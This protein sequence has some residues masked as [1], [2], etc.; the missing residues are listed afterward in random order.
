MTGRPMSSTATCGAKSAQSLQRRERVV[1]HTH[2]MAAI[3]EHAR[4]SRRRRRRCRRRA[5]RAARRGRRPRPVDG[6]AASAS[7]ARF[8]QRQAHD[9][10]A[11]LARHRHCARATL[12]PCSS[13]RLLT[14][15]RPRPETALRRGRSCADPGRNSSK[16]RG[17]MLR[18]DA[19]RRCRVRAMT[20]AWRRRAVRSAR[21]RRRGAC[22]APRWSAGWPPPGPAGSG[23]RASAAPGLQAASAAGGRAARAARWPSRRALA[24]TV[25][26]L[27]GLAAQLDLA[28]CDARH[29]QQVV[30][31]PHQVVDL[32]LDDLL[33]A[34]R[35]V[36]SPRSLIRPQRGDDRRQRV[37]QFVA[38]HR[39]ELVLH[40]ARLLRARA[41]GVPPSSARPPGWRRRAAPPISVTLGKSACSRAHRQHAG[42]RRRSPSPT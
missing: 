36:G 22:S 18:A 8:G 5:G 31:Q 28:A 21:C 33:L 35:L 38:E 25:R 7:A 26:E 2:L 39:Q 3:G 19:D 24:S 20:T 17:S 27:D 9:E 32:A 41:P 10:L 12:P 4:P 16:T 37:A 34:R 15:A 30:D 29:V 40:P 11:A 42:L 23:R 6:A 14:S 1:D 13:T